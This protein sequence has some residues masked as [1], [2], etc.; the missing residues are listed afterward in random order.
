MWSTCAVLEVPLSAPSSPP[1]C[2]R[3]DRHG[4]SRRWSPTR[5]DRP[6]RDPDPAQST[7]RPP[8][9]IEPL[10]VTRPF[11]IDGFEI[12]RFQIDRF[13]FRGFP[14]SPRIDCNVRRQPVGDDRG[15]RAGRLGEPD[16]RRRGG[17]GTGG[18]VR[19]PALRRRPRSRPRRL[20]APSAR[21]RSYSSSLHRQR[22]TR[23][24]SARA[25][26]R[27]RRGRGVVRA[28]ELDDVDCSTAWR[29]SSS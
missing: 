5:P 9:A 22:R 16:V 4:S 8:L 28:G 18:V 11:R 24:R 17:A 29:R 12:D 3:G 2:G 14:S 6:P 21:S 10:T 20:P 26:R 25:R 15:R 13:R 27:S 7:P 19:A 23:P 1:S